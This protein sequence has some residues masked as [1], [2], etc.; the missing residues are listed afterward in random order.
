MAT[1]CVDCHV[2]VKRYLCATE[3][4]C[5]DLLSPASVHTLRL[6]G[7]PMNESEMAEFASN[8]E[9]ESLLQIRIWDEIAKVPG[10]RTRSFAYYVP[11][12]ENL[13]D[14]KSRTGDLR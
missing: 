1:A 12:L 3:S 6:Q 11:L 7:G 5:F 13:I 2:A 14:A 8:P 9:L 10:K 4:D